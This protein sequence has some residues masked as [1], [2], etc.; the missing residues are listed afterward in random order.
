M[1]DAIKPSP[2]I[3]EK[4]IRDHYQGIQMF[5]LRIE[6]GILIVDITGIQQNV[7]S[8]LKIRHDKSKYQTALK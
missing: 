8:L 5:Q 3:F 7:S 2:I 4:Y 1:K 6:T